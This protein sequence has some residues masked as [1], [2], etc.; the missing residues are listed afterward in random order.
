MIVFR[1]IIGVIGG[2]FAA[3]WIA[4]VLIYVIRGDDA[5]KDLGT[6]LRRYTITIALFWI[7]VEVWGR[8]IW[9]IVTWNSPRPD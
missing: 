2:L 6:R 3:G 1:W 7:N 8:V 4:T 9:T 5:W